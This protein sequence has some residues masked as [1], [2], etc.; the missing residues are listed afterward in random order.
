MLPDSRHSEVHRGSAY[1][2]LAIALEL[3]SNGLLRDQSVWLWQSVHGQFDNVENSWE[4]PVLHR[5]MR[6]ISGHWGR[7]RRTRELLVRTELRND[8]G[9]DFCPVA[10]SSTPQRCHFLQNLVEELHAA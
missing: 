1:S 9:L 6:P 2:S 7:V 5:I 4:A 8:R 3:L 10:T